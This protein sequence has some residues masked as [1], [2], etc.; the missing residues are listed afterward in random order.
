ML[1]ICIIVIDIFVEKYSGSNL[2]GFKSI[3]GRITSFFYDEN[4]IGTFIFSFGFITITF[5][6]KDTLID[7][8][9]IFLIY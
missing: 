7:K 2:I 5:F 4:V 8:S 6:L 3:G 9:K 1:T